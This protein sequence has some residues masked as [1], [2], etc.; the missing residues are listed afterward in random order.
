MKGFITLSIVSALVLAGCGSSG[1]DAAGSSA[2][3]SAAIPRPSYV[4]APRLHHVFVIVL[5]NREYLP[6]GETPYLARLRKK[7]ALATH[8]YAITHPS[9]PNYL[10]LLSGSTNGVTADTFS[11]TLGHR[12]LVDQLQAADLTWG[13]YMQ[14]MPSSCFTGDSSGDYVMRHDP[15]MYFS[16]IRANP[17]NCAL[18]R[19][20][21][22]L[23]QALDTGPVPSFVWI[24]PNL[25]AD[26]HDC[27]AASVD[28]FLRQVVPDITASLAYKDRGVLFILYDEGT[29][30]LGCCRLAH[31]G[32]IDV[33]AMGPGIRPGS[34][35]STPADHYSLL[36]TI[37]D[38][39]RL[40]HLGGARCA[41]TPTLG[42]AWK[43]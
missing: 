43:Q 32:R 7:G 42:E 18:V 31:G 21:P 19:P 41:C 8:Y 36:R 30:D 24:T 22:D 37:E 28:G 2:V 25:C 12:T 20:L 4:M 6:G 26:G 3:V 39:F 9:L 1:G 38:G 16:R 5:E 34:T 11:A 17:G 23:F 35:I 33:L 13:A 40:P 10:A 15:F 14:D 27:G 29:T